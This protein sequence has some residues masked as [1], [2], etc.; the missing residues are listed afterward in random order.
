MNVRE[1]IASSR[2][3]GPAPQPDGTHV[4]EFRFPAASPVFS[5]HFPGRPL[6]PGVFQLEMAR[7]AAEQVLCCKLRLRMI[8]RSKFQSPVLPEELVSMR[9]KLSCNADAIHAHARF[10]VGGRMAGETQL[11]LWRDA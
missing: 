2:V 8:P 11:I 1:N 9:L 6:L 5:G 7:M 10:S 4:F 3:N